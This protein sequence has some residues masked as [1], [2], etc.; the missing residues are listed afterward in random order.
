MFFSTNKS[1]L[2]LLLISLKDSGLIYEGKLYYS[3]LKKNTIKDFLKDKWKWNKP[4]IIE[5]IKHWRKNE[6]LELDDNEI[7]IFKFT[8][9]FHY[10]EPLV[11][12]QIGSF[13]I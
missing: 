5:A 9:V 12:R 3:E 4:D 10:Q 13:R 8:E 7:L 1:I 6:L 11:T 2:E